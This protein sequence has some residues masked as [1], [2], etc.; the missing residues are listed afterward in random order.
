[1]PQ[2]VVVAAI[3]APPWLG[4]ELAMPKWPASLARSMTM[5]GAEREASVPG[6]TAPH[7]T[8]IRYA[9]GGVLHVGDHHNFKLWNLEGCLLALP[10]TCHAN[11]LRSPFAMLQWY[12]K[13]FRSSPLDKELL[14]GAPLRKLAKK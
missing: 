14:S 11:L 8:N 9:S 2:E 7:D 13:I 3:L 6:W 4:L 1:M 5:E 12:L 10:F